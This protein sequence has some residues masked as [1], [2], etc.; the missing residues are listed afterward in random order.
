MN[1]KV[2]D[3]SKKMF[4]IFLIEGMILGFLIEFVN[5]GRGNSMGLGVISFCLFLILYF[6]LYPRERIRK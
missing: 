4:W 1:R 5:A 3:N 2:K 6:H